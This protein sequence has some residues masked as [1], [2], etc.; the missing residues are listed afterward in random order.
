MCLSDAALDGFRKEDPN[1]AILAEAVNNAHNHQFS[2]FLCLLSL[3]SVVNLRIEL[4]Y[5][6]GPDN[7]K[8]SL[9][10]M[11]NC[12]IYP[13]EWSTSLQTDRLHIF[14]CAV[15]PLD[16]L[17]TRVVPQTKNHYVAL[18]KSESSPLV[19]EAYI[20]SVLPTFL[21]DSSTEITEMSCLAENPSCTFQENSATCT[22]QSFL[23]E[24]N[25]TISTNSN[26]KGKLKQTLLGRMLTRKRKLTVEVDQPTAQITEVEKQP[27]P[28]GDPSPI[29]KPVTCIATSTEL[30]TNST[31]SRFAND[32]GNYVNP[33]SPL[34]RQ[35]KYHLWCNVWKPDQNIN[36]QWMQEAGDFSI[37]G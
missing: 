17:E 23:S 25:A 13:R 18:C 32:I 4:Y 16:Y 30:S 21:L 8:D 36:S 5:P 22:S 2:S 26:G 27:E 15:L 14:R 31:N 34:T 1:S 6:A 12:T 7:S 28:P 11:F 3:S 37:S 9:A 33:V 29:K 20:T 19:D 10:C 35:Q 24:V